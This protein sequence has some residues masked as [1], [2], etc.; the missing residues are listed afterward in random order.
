MSKKY[1]FVYER[2][3][4]DGGGL[5]AFGDTHEEGHE[6]YL[7]LCAR[8]ECPEYSHILIEIHD[9]ETGLLVWDAWAGAPPIQLP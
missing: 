8:Y 6:E 4:D 7:K 1:K 3:D 9:Q 2:L 5:Y